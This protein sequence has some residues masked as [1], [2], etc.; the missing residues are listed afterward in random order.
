MQPL[1]SRAQ[2]QRQLRIDV[3]RTDMIKFQDLAVRL[4]HDL[5]SH[6]PGRGPDLPRES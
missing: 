4:R 3:C 5:N 2:Q 6:R 1:T